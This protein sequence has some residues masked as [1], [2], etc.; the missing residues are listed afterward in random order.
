MTSD[1][2]TRAG[3]YDLGETLASGE[4]AEVRRG[5]RADGGLPVIIKR[6]RPEWS[7]RPGVGEAFVEAIKDAAPLHHRHLVQL[8]DFGEDEGGRYAVFEAIEGPVLANELIS[9]GRMPA[10]RVRR[11]A[12]GLLKGLSYLHRCANPFTGAPLVH[13]D[14]SPPNILIDAHGEARLA[15][16]GFSRLVHEGR[17][18]GKPAPLL[19]RYLAPEVMASG[20][21][22][23]PRSD[24]FGAGRVLQD[25][26]AATHGPPDL[27]LAHAPS[28]RPRR[29]LPCGSPMVG[30]CSTAWRP[31]CRG[32]AWPGRRALRMPREAPPP[33]CPCPGW[34]GSS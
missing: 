5:R 23:S 8:L 9:G 6:V 20:V 17:L 31:W 29:I 25:L 30:R 18:P 14:V 28:E 13:G 7:R 19:R 26:L 33:S 34:P 24:V 32:P 12:V 10:D 11:I 22:L 16:I 21:G 27:L 4:A 3:P 15:D 1:P 2:R